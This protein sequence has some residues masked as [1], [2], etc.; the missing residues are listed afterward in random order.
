MIAESKRL[1]VRTTK[2]A[3]FRSGR[4][5]GRITSWFRLR[6]SA[7]FS[8]S[9]RPLTV[10]VPGRIKPARASSPTTAGPEIIFAQIFTGGLEIDQQGHVVAVRLPIGQGQLDPGMAGECREMDRCVGRAAD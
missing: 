4:S 1:P 7:L 9:V 2:P 5:I 6:R 3:E 10:K 8:K